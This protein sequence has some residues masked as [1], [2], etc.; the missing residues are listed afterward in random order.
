VALA[1]I[2]AIP[3]LYPPI[4]PL[5]DLLGHMGRYRLELDLATSPWLSRYYGFDWA[6]IGNLGV[7]LLVV[8]L[9]RL[10]GLEP[11]V[12]LIVLAIPVL[13]IAGF[14]FVAREVHQRVP[15][16]ALFALPF[17]YGLPFLYGFVNFTLAMALAFIAFGLWLRLA[18]LDRLR[19]RAILSVPISI[20]L[21]FTHVYGW[22]VL[23][24][25]CFS[26]ETVRQHDRGGG[27]L[28]AAG[29]AALH[30]SVMALPIA[31]MVAWRRE[32][33]GGMTSHWFDWG[34][35]LEWLYT[36]LRDRWKWFDLAALAIALIVLVEARSRKGAGFSRN[37]AFSALVLAAAFLVIPWHVFGSAYADMRLVPYMLATALIAIRIDASEDRRFAQWVAAAGLLFFVVRTAATTTSFAI[38]SN[39][40]TPKLTALDRVPMGARVVTLVGTP[41]GTEWPLP[42]LNHIGSLVIVRRQGFSN[43]QW[44]L[45]GGNLLQLSYAKAGA[46]AADPSQM[47]TSNACRLPDFEPIDGA[48]RKLPRDGFDYVWLV[49]P[50]AYDPGLVAGMRPVW[51]NGRSILYR[52]HP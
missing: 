5:V 2:S 50:P 38:A 28:K 41:C 33:F 7:D 20:V 6:P 30:A 11:A 25:L 16:T 39:D 35:K 49:D 34:M 18:R 40:M 3:L 13:T 29:N 15:P 17:A 36:V 23:G 45:E 14:L 43:D 4:P 22:G 42:R 37:L 19:L 31:F 47:V 51:R 46:F 9:A 24:L 8:P 26:A 10:M 12:K 48:L 1:L 21:F 32:T 27:W 44:L 52:L